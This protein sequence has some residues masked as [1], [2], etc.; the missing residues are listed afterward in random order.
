MPNFGN[1]YG[2]ANLSDLPNVYRII[3]NYGHVGTSAFAINAML[4]PSNVRVGTL[5][6]V[7]FQ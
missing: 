1:S 3:H 5:C 6:E 2:V 7:R 4:N